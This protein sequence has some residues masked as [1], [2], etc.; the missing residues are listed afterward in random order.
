M[1]LTIRQRWLTLLGWIADR[2]RF[3]AAAATILLALSATFIR[4]PDIEGSMVDQLSGSNEQLEIARRISAATGNPSAIAVIVA[5]G[6]LSIGGAFLGLDGLRAALAQLGDAVSVR[7]ID[8]ARDQLFLYGLDEEDPL[9]DLLRVLRETPR[10]ATI[11]SKLSSRFIVVI[12]APETLA[13]EALALVQA[14]PWNDTFED[15]VLLASAQL[16]QDVASG[17]GRDL[18]VLLPAIVAATLAALFVAFAYWRAL[19]LPLFASIASTVVTFALFSATVVTI[20]LVTLLA[21]PVVLIVGLA[22]SCHFLANSE[23]VAATEREVHAAVRKTMLRVGPPFFFSTLTTA[24]ALA[25]LGFNELEP[26]AD[27]GLLSASA[28]LSVFVLVLLAAPLSLRWYLRG[29]GRSWQRSALFATTSGW[30]ATWRKQICA[31]LLVAMLGGAASI[32][33]LSVKSDPR[34]FFPDGA[35]FSAALRLFEEEFYFFSPLRILVTVDDDDPLQGLRRAGQLRDAIADDVPGVLAASMQGAVN[36]DN[37]YVITALLDAEGRLT[38]TLSLVD[39]LTAVDNI[40]AVYSNASLV[41]ES[42]DRQ[43]MESLLRSLGWSVAL[44]FGAILIVFRSLRA[45]VSAMLANAVPLF[46]VC[47]AVWLVGSPLNLVTVFV[48]LV[49]LGVVVD[50]SIHLL[51]WRASGDALSGSSIEFS[52]LL[53]TAVLCLGLLL[54]QLSAFPTTRQ[55]AAYCGLALVAAV[56]SN[57]SVLPFFLGARRSDV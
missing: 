33:L 14:H 21:L 22:N 13:P 23:A 10:S 38:S 46:L 6:E 2:P 5:P 26:I 48:F 17:L 19:L 36:A 41:Y 55:F 20:N 29:S 49:A 43:A 31:A 25:S 40:S 52:V 28:L 57:L 50:D 51:F 15:Y 54:W 44:I 53:S 11:I 37:S 1:R 9:K 35:P 4:A 39:R 16:E 42:I 56:I 27:L 3:S 45:L 12:N 8:S 34:A 18:R 24:I 7:S 30:L 47:G 32:P